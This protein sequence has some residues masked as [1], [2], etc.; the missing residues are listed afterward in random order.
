MNPGHTSKSVSYADMV[1]HRAGFFSVERSFKRD[2]LRTH[3]FIMQVGEWV[4]VPLFICVEWD[5]DQVW[6]GYCR[7]GFYERQQRDL[8]TWFDASLL[9]HSMF[10]N[11]AEDHFSYSAGE[12]RLKYHETILK[13]ARFVHARLDEVDDGET[14]ATRKWVNHVLTTGDLNS[15]ALGS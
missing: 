10:P 4:P 12:I 11:H 5:S 13:V 6:L 8:E 2:A 15:P 14:P 1:A 3:G 9:I 7:P